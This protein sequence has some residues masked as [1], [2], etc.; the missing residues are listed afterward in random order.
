MERTVRDWSLALD[1]ASALNLPAQIAAGVRRDVGAGTLRPGEPMPSSRALAQTLGVSR[2]TVEAAYDQLVAEGYLLSRPRSGMLVNPRLRATVPAP[3]EGAGQSRAEDPAPGTDLDLVP[4]HDSNSPLVDPA[5][6]SA[7][8]RAADTER[9]PDQRTIDPTGDPVLRRAVAEHLRLMRG[10][11]V[12]PAQVVVTAGSREGL[13]LLLAGLVADGRSGPLR[14]GVEDP[15]FPGLRR[16]LARLGVATVPLPVDGSGLVVPTADDVPGVVLVTPNH[17]YPYGSAMPA[18]R[19]TEL[20]DWASTT[21]TLVVEDDYD[22][23]FRYVGSPPPALYGLSPGAPVVHLAT[24]SAVLSRDVGT[25]YLLLPESLV[26]PVTR[27]RQDLGCPVAPILQ[28]AVAH[29]LDDGG[30]RRR[31]QRS[32]R[33]LAAT[34]RLVAEVLERIPGAVDQ[35]RMLVVERPPEVA[36]A[37]LAGCAERGLLLGD[38]ADGWSGTPHSTGVVLGYG[39]VDEAPLARGLTI[40]EDVLAT[41]PDPV[42]PTHRRSDIPETL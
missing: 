20:L 34:H 7:W 40:L 38:L 41:T 28:R 14:V 15:G 1:P 33:R 10:L 36:A 25:G 31:L 29:Y 3:R 6:R 35:G 30:L 22:S 18:T 9:L 8:R 19:R 37:V 4:G 27:I 12:D 2:G 26:G 39:A 21:G 32:R 42:A 11:L 16:T 5:W 24:F 17:Q 23:E 13:A